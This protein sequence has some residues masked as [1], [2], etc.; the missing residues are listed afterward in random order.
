MSFNQIQRKQIIKTDIDTLW[1]FISSPKNLKKITPKSMIFDITSDITEKMY[2][3]LIISYKVAPM[4]NIPMTWVTEITHIK[5]KSFFV[6]QQILGPYK[7]WHHQHILIET[8]DGILMH[9]IISYI[10]P[11]GIFGNILNFL[12][13]RKK[14]NQI[15]DYR[16]SELDKIF[17]KN[18]SEINL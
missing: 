11:Y 7:F 18:R 5:E 14:I 3:G 15:F 16:K 2:S 9:D 12:F 8:K 17:N 1:A 4:L 6:D 13:I 10:P